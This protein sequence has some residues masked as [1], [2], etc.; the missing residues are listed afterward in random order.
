MILSTDIYYTYPN[1]LGQIGGK[2]IYFLLK[3][4]ALLWW[5]IVEWV[6]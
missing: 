4:C 6:R 5:I 3:E 1:Y 2:A